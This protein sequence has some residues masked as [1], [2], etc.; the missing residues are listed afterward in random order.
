M[1]E[2]GIVILTNQRL[3]LLVFVKFQKTLYAH[4]T[5]PELAEEHLIALQT[6]IC[7]PSAESHGLHNIVLGNG[8]EFLERGLWSLVLRLVE[9]ECTIASMGNVLPSS[10]VRAV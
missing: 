8:R 2:I 7:Q 9:R 3:S 10:R 5:L 4:K 1:R 6:T